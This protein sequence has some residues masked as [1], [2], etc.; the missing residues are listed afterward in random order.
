MNRQIESRSGKLEGLNDGVCVGIDSRDC[1]VTACNFDSNKVVAHICFDYVGVP[2]DVWLVKRSAAAACYHMM[3]TVY[4]A[5]R[6][7]V[8]MTVEYQLDPI[9]LEEWL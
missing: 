8:V 1:T 7:V 4:E 3:D 6:I 2:V 9:R 5:T